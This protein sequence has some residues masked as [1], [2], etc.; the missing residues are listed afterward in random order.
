MAAHE[1][2]QGG[3]PL[4]RHVRADPPL[5][6]E[7][8]HQ[9]RL[10]HLHLLLEEALGLAQQR[11]AQLVA[12][13]PRKLLDLHDEAH[14]R[15]P[16]RLQ[17][18]QRKAKVLLL[19]HEDEAHDASLR[20][21]AAVLEALLQRPRDGCPPLGGPGGRRSI[22]ANGAAVG[23]RVSVEVPLAVG[24][25]RLA[26]RE[27]REQRLEGR[28]EAVLEGLRAQ[29]VHALR[30]HH[31]TVVGIGHARAALE[32][33]ALD[34]LYH[35]GA[36][37][38]LE[39]HLQPLV[40]A[41][42]CELHALAAPQAL[43]DLLQA[44][45]GTALPALV[46]IEVALVLPLH[47][48]HGERQRLRDKHAHELLRHGLLVLN[49]LLLE[50]LERVHLHQVPVEHVLRIGNNVKRRAE[51]AVVQQH[52]DGLARVHDL[53]AAAHERRERL[54]VLAA[55]LQLGDAPALHGDVSLKLG[56]AAPERQ[57]R[58]AGAAH[59]PAHHF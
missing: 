44:R 31:G 39:L 1:A 57:H 25:D 23:R 38:H 6:V 30:R 35:H 48:L 9:A 49:Q 45:P 20:E 7:R 27:H 28:I 43:P 46:H 52:L 3:L 17:V 2:L 15:V 5:R 29:G 11:A 59:L 41:A 21:L 55:A 8:A 24:D 16:E 50:R 19:A 10:L 34:V 14:H 37:H 54:A 56:D 40:E 33:L 36:Q 4:R 22:T 42:D 18:L 58:L 47:V 51:L 13:D 32:F 26:A 12:R 53:H